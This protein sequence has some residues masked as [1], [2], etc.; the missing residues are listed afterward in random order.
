MTARRLTLTLKTPTACEVALKRCPRCGKEKL[1][2]A[3]H[4][5][6]AAADGLQDWCKRCTLTYQ[7]QARAAA[8]VARIVARINEMAARAELGKTCCRCGAI[9]P[10]F[11]FGIDSRK[12]DGRKSTCK[13]CAAPGRR[14][15]WATY[16]AKGAGSGYVS[17][18]SGDTK[19]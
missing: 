5:N 2:R 7:K 12:P 14:A 9:K 3:F 1:P 8:T 15:A 13:P 11:D 19:V 17:T 16:R 18:N 10:L 4:K 6:G